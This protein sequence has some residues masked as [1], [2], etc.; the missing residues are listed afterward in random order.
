MTFPALRNAGVY[1]PPQLN[2]KRE[3]TYIS[4]EARY[5]KS[6]VINQLLNYWQLIIGNYL[7]KIGW[8]RQSAFILKVAVDIKDN[9]INTKA[10]CEKSIILLIYKSEYSE[11]MYMLLI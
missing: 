5:M 9:L 6:K 11:Q 3:N 4:K 8:L 1:N 2:Q 10:T 7:T